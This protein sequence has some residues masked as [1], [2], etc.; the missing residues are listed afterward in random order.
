MT[1]LIVCTNFSET[2]RN[3]FNYACSLLRSKGDTTNYRIV[4]LHIYTIYANYSGDG[5]ALTTVNN[6]L[7]FSED[8]LA[9]ELQ[10]AQ[11]EFPE[12][13]VA[14]KITTGHFLDGLKD[15]ITATSANMVILGTGGNYGDLWLWDS[16][17]LHALRN[18]PVPVLTIP[19]GLQFAHF[20]NI[21]LACNLKNNDLFRHLP[22]VTRLVKFTEAQLHIIYVTAQQLK[23][24]SLEENNLRMLQQELQQIQPVY[25]TLYENEVVD[26]IGH[27]VEENNIQLLLVMPRKHGLWDNLFHKSYTKQLSRLGGLP[28]MAVH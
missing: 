12:L 15:E 21:A 20:K 3:A 27:F 16:N 4:L 17:I 24:G 5:I 26:A 11:T 18:L 7:Q 28:I 1:T 22:M 13:N 14:T 2:S 6:A 23:P 9:E 25:K 8:D 10:W 19:P